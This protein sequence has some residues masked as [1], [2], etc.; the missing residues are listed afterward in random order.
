MKYLRQPTLELLGLG[1]V[2][3]IFQRG[4]L[5]V[6][7][8]ELVE[9]VFGKA[10]ER[11]ALVISGAN[12]IVGAG[13]MVQL[14]SRLQPFGVPM[15]GLDFPD[16]PDGIGAQYPGLFWE[17]RRVYQYVAFPSSPYTVL[18]LGDLGTP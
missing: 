8:D 15:V 16:A 9:Q 1:S 10:T 6:T 3:E 13:K 2:L 11:G 7:T 17:H 4:Q 5:P 18:V 14:G 12:G